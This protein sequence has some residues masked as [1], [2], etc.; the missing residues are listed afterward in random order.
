MRKQS[1]LGATAALVA[2]GAEPTAR[3]D[4]SSTVMALNPVAHWPPNATI[5]PAAGVTATTS[6]GT[7]GS[8]FNVTFKGNLTFGVHGVI[9]S[10]SDTADGFD[11]NT[12]QA[13][14]PYTA[15]AVMW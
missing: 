11:G 8:A 6:L 1:L 5:S 4:S 13:Q 2:L 15:A 9:A 10:E 14:T 12:T 7:L 3:A